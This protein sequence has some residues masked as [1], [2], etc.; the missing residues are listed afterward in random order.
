MSSLKCSKHAVCFLMCDSRPTTGLAWRPKI[1]VILPQNLPIALV[2]TI[3]LY[4]TL[5]S[6]LIVVVPEYS[7][8]WMT[9]IIWVPFVCL[10]C[11]WFLSQLDKNIE[12]SHVLKTNLRFYLPLFSFPVL[13]SLHKCQT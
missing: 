11:H 6:N 3:F 10:F 4:E 8:H 13:C 5:A 2:F 1:V 9:K 7:V 12:I